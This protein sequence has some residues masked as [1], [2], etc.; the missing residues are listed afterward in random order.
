[1]AE[2]WQQ[3]L[4]TAREP[5]LRHGRWLWLALGAFVLVSL[6][7]MLALVHPARALGLPIQAWWP[8]AWPLWAQALLMVLPVDFLRY[9]LHRM[10]C[11]APLAVIVW[12]LLFG[13]WFLPREPRR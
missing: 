4:V 1:M 3:Q 6:L 12:D 11:G 5:G 9:W 2:P 8:H 7:F 13:T 10:C